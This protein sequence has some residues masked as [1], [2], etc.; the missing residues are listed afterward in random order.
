MAPSW[1]PQ[2][3]Q[4]RVFKYVLNKLAVFSNLDLENLD[5]SL[6][7]TSNLSVNDVELDTEKLSIPGVYVRQGGVRKLNVQLGVV[8]GVKLEGSDIEAT[9]AIS[10]Y[11]PNEDD[12]DLSALLSKTTNDIA[13]SIMVKEAK[14]GLVEEGEVDEEADDNGYGMGEFSTLVSRLVDAAMAQLIVELRNIVIHIVANESIK[15]DLLIDEIL[16][17]TGDDGLRHA[18]VNGTRLVLIEHDSA[19]QQSGYEPESD[20]GDSDEDESELMQSTV[21]SREEASTMYMSALSDMADN[22]PKI[23]QRPVLECNSL[24]FSFSGIAGAN[25]QVEIASVLGTVESFPDAL[26]PLV[27]FANNYLFVASETDE[28]DEL[29][30]QREE[31]KYEVDADMP[32]N[33]S[34]KKLA[35]SSVKLKLGDQTESDTYCV[36]SDIIV[37][38]KDDLFLEVR[39]VKAIRGENPILWFANDEEEP[40]SDFICKIKP[41]STTYLLPNSAMM[42][43]AFEDLVLLGDC[44]DDLILVTAE[45]GVDE[46]C[47]KGPELTKPVSA[48]TNTFSLKLDTGVNVVSVTVLPLSFESESG[49]RIGR[50]KGKINNNE[51]LEI[52]PGTLCVSNMPETIV[53]R[54][55]SE[56]VSTQVMKKLLVDKVALKLSER[57]LVGIFSDVKRLQDHLVDHRAAKMPSLKNEEGR[58]RNV[59]ISEDATVGPVELAISIKSIEFILEL[60]GKLGTFNLD[61][62]DL[63]ANFFQNKVQSTFGTVNASRDFSDIDPEAKYVSLIHTANPL[64]RVSFGFF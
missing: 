21:F 64:L 20:S 46:K 44:V 31:C 2:N 16:F 40:N 34:L 55:D 62:R 9:V 43:V 23:V 58:F 35:I 33:F 61:F 45:L 15:M 56:E 39:K 49:L 19:A 32:Q 6:G 41:L 57:S 3:I 42:D 53:R 12:Q 30:V 10:Q 13:E 60:E 51:I 50:I 26:I 18:T 54:Q 38:H 25:L 1:M 7:R 5:V 8:S 4:K 48:Q 37:T 36:L 17:S 29:P 63:D 22:E 47:E 27:R 52:D 14:K 11:P 24:K 28:S 59:R